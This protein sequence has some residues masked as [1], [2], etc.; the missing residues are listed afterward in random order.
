M[1]APGEPTRPS[2]AVR[3]FY[4]RYWGLST[5]PAD[6]TCAFSKI[7]GE[8]GVFS[9]FARTPLVVDG[10]PFDTSERL[11]QT[12]KFADPEARHAVYGAKGNPKMTAKKWQKASPGARRADWWERLVDAMKFCLN[13]KFR[14]SEAF[15]AEL[16]RTGDRPIVEDQTTFPR[17]TAD[18]WGAKRTPDGAS[19]VGPNLLGRLLMEL[20]DGGGVLA[21]NRPLPADMVSFRDLA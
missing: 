4:P 2:D 20:R 19:F 18:A 11:F 15:R 10:V 9:N 13:A 21:Y 7:V 6:R 12:M 3:I 1:T 17:A 8:W 16:A 14:Q 5:Y